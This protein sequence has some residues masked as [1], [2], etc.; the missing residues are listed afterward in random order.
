MVQR[1]RPH[2]RRQV[3]LRRRILG[4]PD[5]QFV[6]RQNPQ[7]EGD[8][9]SVLV[10]TPQA[11][12]LPFLLFFDTENNFGYRPH[13]HHHK[14]TRLL[15]R[16]TRSTA[17]AGS[18]SE[19]GGTRALYQFCRCVGCLEKN[20]WAAHLLRLSAAVLFGVGRPL[21]SELVEAC[22]HVVHVRPHM[23]SALAS[24]AVACWGKSSWLLSCRS[25]SDVAR[26]SFG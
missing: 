6:A 3:P 13:H 14:K 24:A 23:P 25:A 12:A 19:G 21:R 5:L 16:S 4:T 17:V 22:K 9:L 26:L 11:I 20:R 1:K 7:S 10:F 8:E 2:R 15:H 18:L